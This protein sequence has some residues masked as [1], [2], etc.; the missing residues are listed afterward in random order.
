MTTLL[1]VSLSQTSLSISVPLVAASNDLIDVPVNHLFPW[2]YFKVNHTCPA[3]YATMHS[4]G[5]DSMS[6]TE[7]D[8]G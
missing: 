8:R 4:H 1:N 6:H 3:S 2:L 7:V 5:L